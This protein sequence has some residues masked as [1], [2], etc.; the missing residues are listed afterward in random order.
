MYVHMYH[1]RYSTSAVI[2]LRASLDIISRMTAALSESAGCW[3][4]MHVRRSHRQG[5][6]P[7]MALGHCSSSTRR[8]DQFW[9]DTKRLKRSTRGETRQGRR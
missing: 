1:T 4:T 8:L 3:L 7:A 9:A 5:S 6:R 2:S